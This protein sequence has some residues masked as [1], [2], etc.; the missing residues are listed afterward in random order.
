MSIRTP[1]RHP[2]LPPF[3][4]SFDV[5]R[6]LQN[7]L[8][9]SPSTPPEISSD[10]TE[11]PPAMNNTEYDS[12]S[13]MDTVNDL[14]ESVYYLVMILKDNPAYIR[15]P[16]KSRLLIMEF[17]PEV[18][19]RYDELS[20]KYYFTQQPIDNALRLKPITRIIFALEKLLIKYDISHFSEREVNELDELNEYISTAERFRGKVLI[21]RRT[22][23]ETCLIELVQTHKYYKTVTRETVYQLIHDILRSIH[24]LSMDK[25][26][27]LLQ[28]YETILKLVNADSFDEIKTTQTPYIDLLITIMTEGIPDHNVLKNRIRSIINCFIEILQPPTELMLVGGRTN[29]S[30]CKTKKT[31][32]RRKNKNS[33]NKTKCKK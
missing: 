12:S 8:D 21:Y 1:A 24:D 7:N 29:K 18:L 5:D 6:Y 2:P 22:R 13:S 3:N 4:T 26:V 17:Y 32:C 19:N 20:T 15:D 14:S 30:K 23:L 33:K 11:A 16:L 10:T 25:R 31:K 28:K 9:I 27:E